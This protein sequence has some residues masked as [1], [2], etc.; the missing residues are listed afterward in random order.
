MNSE[1]KPI[2]SSKQAHTIKTDWNK[3][4]TPLYFKKHRGWIKIIDNKGSKDAIF[5]PLERI[6]GVDEVE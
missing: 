4:D 2:H 3:N 6:G 5:T 1:K